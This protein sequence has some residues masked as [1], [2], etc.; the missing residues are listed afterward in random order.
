MPQPP[1]E[2]EDDLLPTIEATT[3]P[4]GTLF[5]SGAKAHLRV[6]KGKGGYP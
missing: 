4:V 5:A 1:R 2:N 3:L 6:V